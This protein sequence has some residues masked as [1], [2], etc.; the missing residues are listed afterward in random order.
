MKTL[1]YIKLDKQGIVPVVDEL[2]KLLADIQVF[3]TNLRGFHWNVKGKQFF[4]LHEK[5]EEI[6]DDMNEKADEVAERILMLGHVP[7]NNYSDY[8]KMSEIKEVSGVSDGKEIV[9]RILDSFTSLM[10]RERK[11][12]YLAGKAEDEV[13]VAIMSDYL[14]EQEKTVWM[15]VA[16]L[17]E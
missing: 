16:Y 7:A 15:L 11:V 3:Y 14:K 4:M 10:T 6:Y 17:D 13:T 1:D 2:H 5:F 8:L 9:K 12:L